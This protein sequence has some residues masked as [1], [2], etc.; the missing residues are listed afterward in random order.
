MLFLD[1][2]SYSGFS[3]YHV[4]IFA[5]EA[6]VMLQTNLVFLVKLYTGFSTVHPLLPGFCINGYGAHFCAAL[7]LCTLGSQSKMHETLTWEE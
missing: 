2:I 1:L 5:F 7:Q 6:S 4:T 3:G